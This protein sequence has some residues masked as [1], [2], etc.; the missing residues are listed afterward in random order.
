MDLTNILVHVDASERAAE[1]IRLAAN[2]A[3]TC[4]AHV[5]GT[6]AIPDPYIAAYMASGYVPVEIFETQREEAF[7]QSGDA[8]KVFEDIVSKAGVKGE[9]RTEE[10]AVSDVVARHARY[11]DLAVVG[12]GDRDDPVKYP[13]PELS[14]DLVMTCGRPVLVVPNS[15]GFE[16][17][18]R[19]ILVCWNASR[20]ATRAVNDAMPFLAKADKVTVLAVNPAKS[21]GGDHGEIPSADIALHLARHGVK[22]EASSTAADRIEISDV[23]LARASDLGADLI[24]SGA[25]GHS[26]TREWVFGGVTENLMRD[27]TVPVLMSH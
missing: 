5:T 9:Y 20:E 19:R 14:G 15:G 27:T 21:S 6:F 7:K 18:G 4:D 13:Y 12:K 10:G 17:V 3:K 23:I 26:R 1:R 24:V 2:I 16:T 11:A 8:R 22:A 25:Y